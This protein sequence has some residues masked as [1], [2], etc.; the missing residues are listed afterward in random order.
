VG[1]YA[2]PSAP[3]ADGVLLTGGIKVANESK[4]G[5][6]GIAFGATMGSPHTITISGGPNC[7]GVFRLAAYVGHLDGFQNV[8]VD[9]SDNPTVIMV[10][11]A[12]LTL[13][14]NYGIIGRNFIDNALGGSINVSWPLAPAKSPPR[15]GDDAGR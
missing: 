10:S 6:L 13:D 15:L 2:S 4:T 9:Q 1:H 5:V 14:A 8:P 3:A 11:S 12:N 7:T